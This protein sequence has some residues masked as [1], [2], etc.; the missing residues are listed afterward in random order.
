M[1]SIN[2]MT[3]E[4]WKRRPSL[5]VLQFADFKGQQNCPQKALK[6]QNNLWKQH[7]EI[8]NALIW[9][10]LL[11]AVSNKNKSTISYMYKCK[12]ET[13][14]NMYKICSW[15]PHHIL[16]LSDIFFIYRFTFQRDAA[17]N[18]T[19]PLRVARNNGAWE[20]FCSK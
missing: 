17:Y 13:I 16:Y 10:Q 20:F 7:T 2:C 15:I 3:S 9:I 19:L 6:H 11:P 14:S 18:F 12:M 8:N 1:T 5:P 4:K